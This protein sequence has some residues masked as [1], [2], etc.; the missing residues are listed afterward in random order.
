MIIRQVQLYASEDAV[1][2]PHSRRDDKDLHWFS[3]I[4]Q[5]TEN[6]QQ[7]VYLHSVQNEVHEAN[8]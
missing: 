4:F 8:D 7:C 2:T 1:V 3:I 5:T 6:T